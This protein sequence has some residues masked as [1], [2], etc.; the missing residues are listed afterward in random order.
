MP[1]N[2]N[3]NA[4]PTMRRRQVWSIVISGFG[5]VSDFG[6]GAS[7]FAHAV[8]VAAIDRAADRGRGRQ[9]LFDLTG[10]GGEK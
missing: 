9:T 1:T 5:F 7:C 6:F 10:K 2:R 4:R 3:Q 8:I